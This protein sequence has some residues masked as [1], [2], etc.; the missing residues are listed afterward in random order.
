[1]QTIKMPVQNI[2]GKEELEAYKLDKRDEFE[3]A[4]RRRRHHMG[5]W[6]KYARWEERL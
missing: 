6:M 3:E 4:I 5:N 1:M 2:Q